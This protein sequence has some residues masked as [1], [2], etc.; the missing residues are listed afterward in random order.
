MQALLADLELVIKNW[1]RVA[2]PIQMNMR[3]RG[4]EHDASTRLAI[5]IR[6][7]GLELY[8]EHE[9]LDQAQRVTKMLQNLFFELP[10]VM[11]RV[12]QDDSALKDIREKKTQAKQN[13]EQWASEIS[14]DVSIGLVFK[15]KLRISPDGIEWKGRT[16]PLESIDTV[17]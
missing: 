11:E 4:L 13:Q 10:G 7:L 6:G 5:T 12:A 9:M 1:N 14:Y 16:Y 15:D 3:V 17:W 2:R 8:N